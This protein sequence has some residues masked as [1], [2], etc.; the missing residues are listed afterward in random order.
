MTLGKLIVKMIPKYEKLFD[1][2]VKKFIRSSESFADKS[3]GDSIEEMRKSYNEMVE[4][5]RQAR[6]P[7]V[8]TEDKKVEF[9]ERA[10]IYRHYSKSAR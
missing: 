4:H 3:A 10:L 1:D 6:P 5:F 7:N 8:K 9:K 2:E